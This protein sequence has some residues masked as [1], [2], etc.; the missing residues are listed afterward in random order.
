MTRTF[1]EKRTN[2]ELP[3]PHYNNFDMN[4]DAQCIRGLGEE[5]ERRKAFMNLGVH[6][7][8]NQDSDRRIVGFKKTSGSGHP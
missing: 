7:R 8:L 6:L 3:S 2:Y 5:G 1:L 4:P